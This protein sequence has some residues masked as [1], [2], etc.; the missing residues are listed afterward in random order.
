V[1]ECDRDASIMRRLWRTRGY[2]AMENKKCW[3]MF[4]LENLERNERITLRLCLV[5]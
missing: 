4:Q 1:S 5:G 2:G 3:K